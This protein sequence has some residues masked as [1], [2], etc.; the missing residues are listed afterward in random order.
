MKQVQIKLTDEER[1]D[2]I[3]QPVRQNVA[4]AA[5]VDT[6]IKAHPGWK[7]VPRRKI[8]DRTCNPFHGKIAKKVKAN[9]YKRY[10]ALSSTVQNAAPSHVTTRFGGNFR[11]RKKS[12]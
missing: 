2:T 10:Q 12:A 3:N 11:G 7:G 8:Q 5:I 4:A 6:L 1:T 9:L